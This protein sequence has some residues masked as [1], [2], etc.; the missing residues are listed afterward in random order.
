M[1]SILYIF[2]V[3]VLS[4]CA[5]KPEIQEIPITADVNAEIQSL[6]GQ[7]NAAVAE[8]VNVL[9][10]FN[11]KKAQDALTDAKEAQGKGKATK[12]VLHKVAVGKAYIE[13][14]YQVADKGHQNIE[15]LIAVRARAIEAGAPN[16]FSKEFEK[17]DNKFLAI[18]SELE[19]D[20]IKGA[21]KRSSKVQEL[22]LDLELKAIKQARLGRA[23]DL[24]KQG[25]KDDG[26]K[27]APRSLETA[28][29]KIKDAED[30]ITANRT[31]VYEINARSNEALAA[32]EQFLKIAHDAKHNKKVSP[33][34]LA[35]ELDSGRKIISKKDAE[36]ADSREEE[37]RLA[38]EKRELEEL[39]SNYKM[40]QEAFSRDEAEVYK[41]DDKL[42]IRLKGLAFPA[43]TANLQGEKLPLLHK[44]E[45]VIKS[46]GKSEVVVEGYTDSDGSK[47][48][49]DKLSA[50]R[51]KVVKDYLV[52]TEAVSENDISA[53]GLGDQKPVATNKTAMGK[54][55]N[56]RV[57]VI[58]TPM[59]KG[60]EL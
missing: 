7:V 31:S 11:F 57:D 6:D 32:A 1:K 37:T 14:S 17:A 23:K 38:N 60:V 22:Y 4:A 36:L 49:N 20:D 39:E 19:D 21:V 54:A 52:S 3:L 55:Q 18:G 56:R 44:V 28:Q 47:K 30:F 8:Q 2:I 26:K 40:A 43:A 59:K 25:I 42:I 16:Y 15:E 34:D 27:Y 9:S 53:I 45:E 5:H 10:P 58:I 12:D 24:V 29:K 41:Q 46:F 48:A 13:K 35:L 50:E 33:E 51:A